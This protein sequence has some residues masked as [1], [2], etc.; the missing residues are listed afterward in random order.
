[1]GIYL[2][3]EYSQPAKQPAPR[4]QYG[5]RAGKPAYNNNRPQPKSIDPVPLPKDFVEKAERVMSDPAT[6][7]NRKITTSKIRRLFS[8]FTD[9]YNI[10]NRRTEPALTEEN[11]GRLRL[12]QIRMLYE[13]GRDRTVKD[14]LD[15]AGLVSH[16]KAVDDDRNAF[17]CYFHYM[18][19]LVAYHKYF[20]G[21]E[22]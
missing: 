11:V 18:E 21:R 20:G 10:E 22:G 4:T 6:E 13:A 12:A 1:M 14:F 9:I 16:L 2:G 19:A 5:Q 17:I 3:K 7:W 8:L 15:S